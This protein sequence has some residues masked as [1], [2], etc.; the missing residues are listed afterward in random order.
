MLSDVAGL[1]DIVGAAQALICAMKPALNTLDGVAICADCASYFCRLDVGELGRNALDTE[2]PGW[3][4]GAGVPK[5]VLPIVH[6]SYLLLRSLESDIRAIDAF[7]DSLRG[8]VHAP[9]GKA[10][11]K[12]IEHAQ[13][14]FPFFYW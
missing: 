14:C 9:T 6:D 7:I 11:V 13:L 2:L 4:V 1:H 5:L 3:R 10:L 8:T 12:G